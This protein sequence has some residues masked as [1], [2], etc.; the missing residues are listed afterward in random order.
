MVT[1][2][3]V[4]RDP[5]YHTQEDLPERLDTARMARVVEGLG[6]VLAEFIDAETKL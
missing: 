1:D 6:A 2:T 5:H 4:F 3:A